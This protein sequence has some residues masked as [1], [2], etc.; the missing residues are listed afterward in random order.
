MAKLKYFDFV[1]DNDVESA[2]SLAIERL[3]RNEESVYTKENYLD[4]LNTFLFYVKKLGLGKS[5]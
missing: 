3:E 2:M 1:R 5:M 4:M